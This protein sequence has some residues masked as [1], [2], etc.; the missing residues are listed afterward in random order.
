[1]LGCWSQTTAS[2]PNPA[3]VSPAYS[4]TQ[5]WTQDSSWPQTT[6]FPWQWRLEV[7]QFHVLGLKT[8][9]LFPELLFWNDRGQE[10]LRGMRGSHGGR[11]DR[12]E[13]GQY[14]GGREVWKM[15]SVLI[16]IRVLWSCTSRVPAPSFLNTAPSPDLPFE[17]TW[18]AN[19]NQ[20]DMLTKH[21]TEH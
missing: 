18:K 16:M 5:W 19:T 15:Q 9:T 17:Q 21:M 7:S 3:P 8:K 1:M 4:P 14:S 20:E 2:S 13:W 11:C 6:L 12:K 10:C